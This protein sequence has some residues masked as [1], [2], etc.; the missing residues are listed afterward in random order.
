[1]IEMKSGDGYESYEGQEGSY[2]EGYSGDGIPIF[3]RPD[4]K[5]KQCELSAF[6]FCLP[7]S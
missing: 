4:H 3:P 7:L 6:V 5:M 2:G 1:M